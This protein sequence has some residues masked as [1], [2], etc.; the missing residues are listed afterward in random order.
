MAVVEPALG[1]VLLHK[2][3]ASELG[4]TL[5]SR[6]VNVSG[7][8]MTG[9]LTVGGIVGIA[10]TPQ[11][12][13]DISEDGATTE[14][15]GDVRITSYGFGPRFIG[16]FAKGSLAAPTQSL[17][18]DT[19]FT[20]AGTGYH[21]GGAFGSDNQSRA[22]LVAAEDWTSSAQ[23]TYWVW[24]QNRKGTSNARTRLAL[25]PDKTLTDAATSLFDVALQSGQMAGGTIMWTIEA[26]NGT[27][28]QAYSGITTYA[29]V[30]KAAA[31]TTSITHNTSNDSKAVSS[32]TLTVVWSITTGADKI[33]IVVTPT[34][35]LTETTY[36]ITYTILNTTHQEITIL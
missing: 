3:K 9:D 31:Y 20:L 22:A 10:T 13:L 8:T 11:T 33:T 28:H 34:G 16:R 24:R 26:S 25:A 35:S 18:G 21:S 6:Y 17:A 7:D 19:L 30:N 5:D 12:T 14:R 32:G 23:G 15:N 4:A 2:H 1:Q 29:A 27:D 36:R